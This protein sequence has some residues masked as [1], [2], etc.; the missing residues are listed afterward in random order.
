MS[1][2][3][4]KSSKGKFIAGALVG[5]TLGVLFAPK[6]GSETRKQLKEKLNEMITKVKDLDMKEVKETIENKVNEIKHELEDLDREK[7]F[8]I[9]KNKATSLK[10][11]A[12][13][14]FNYAVEK[15]TPVLEKTASAIR[16]KTIEV[17]KEILAKLEKQQENAKEEN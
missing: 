6:K 3:K 15:G 5:A 14:L 9:A 4:K 10:N 8:K 13:D 2:D 12:E 17:T 16:E 1:K 11:K 7:V